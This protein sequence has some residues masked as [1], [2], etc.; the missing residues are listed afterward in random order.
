MLSETFLQRIR[1]ISKKTVTKARCVIYFMSRDQRIEENQALMATQQYAIDKGLPLVVLFILKLNSKVRAQ[2]HYEFMLKGLQELS[3]L[4]IHYDIPMIIR[5]G[6]RRD[7]LSAIINDLTPDSIFLDFSPLNGQKSIQEFLIE[8][9]VSV[10]VVDTHNIVPVWVTSQK[11]E[12]SA[13]T[14]RRKIQ[15]HLLEYLEKQPVKVRVHPFTMRELNIEQ[16]I[17]FLRNV[18][19]RELTN[20]S[21]IIKSGTKAALATLE[22]FLESKIDVYQELRNDPSKNGQSDL[23]GYLHFGQISSLQ[24]VKEVFNK[25]GNN[26]ENLPSGPATFIEEIIVR[27][28]LSDNFC[29]Y[30]R[31]Y[32]LLD[33]APAWARQTLA[34]HGEDKRQYTYSIE[35]LE[36]A[37]THDLSWNA[38]QRQ[39]IQT[40]KM[41]GYMRMYWA[42]KILE[43]SP[44]PKNAIESAIYLND[45]YELDGYDP[46]GYVGIL[47]SITGLH[48]RPWFEREIYGTVRYMNEA[49][50]KRKFDLDTYIKRWTI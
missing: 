6:K 20:Y 42:K 46:N 25:Y 14:I 29:Y 12:W 44:S 7:V 9:R 27:K 1:I 21:L 40:G 28:E 45:T 16:P 23:S 35:Q 11:Q 43:W 13:Y 26:I 37:M 2:Q 47:W 24:I 38:A 34:R 5:T 17:S 15:K 41:H 32:R 4:L 48:D 31:N 10:F 3:F 30:N 22:D 8:Q 18:K 33:G 39:M 50:L 19:V 36:N 49:G